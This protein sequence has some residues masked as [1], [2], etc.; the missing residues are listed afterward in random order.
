M[1]TNAIVIAVL[2]IING[3]IAVPIINLLKSLLHINGG[4]QSYVLTAA[5][6]MAITA[7]YLLLAL[8]AFT[9]PTF[10]MA[11]AYAFLQASKIYDEIK[12]KA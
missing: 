11:S 3:A 8:K 2:A 10:L 9:W 7:G 4:W 6:V 5:E 12:A 1:D